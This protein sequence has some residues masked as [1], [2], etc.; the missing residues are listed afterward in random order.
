MRTARLLLGV[1]AASFAVLS[2]DPGHA[3]QIDSRLPEGPNRA[4][5]NRV[6]TSCHDIGNLVATNGR[7][8][9]GWSVKIDDMVLYGLK[10]TPEDRAMVLDY[11]ATFLPP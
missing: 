1:A 6:C 2:I 9:A 5:V 8:R 11:L 3:Q 10:I 7:S 4:L